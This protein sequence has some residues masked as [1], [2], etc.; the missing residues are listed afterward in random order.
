M[1][2]C[3][4]FVVVVVVNIIIVFQT[5]VTKSYYNLIMRMANILKE[6]KLNIKICEN[7]RLC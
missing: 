1:Q 5:N 7:M 6:M 2:T 4:N 3:Y